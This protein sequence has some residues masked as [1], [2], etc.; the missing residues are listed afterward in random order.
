M[1]SDGGEPFPST[2]YRKEWV[3]GSMWLVHN[4]IDPDLLMMRHNLV[5]SKTRSLLLR[6]RIK[7]E[8]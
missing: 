3:S 4:H 5:E 7:T 8:D 2:V 6:V 1:W